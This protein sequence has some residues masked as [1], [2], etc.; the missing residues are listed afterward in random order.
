MHPRKRPLRCVSIGDAIAE[1]VLGLSDIPFGTCLDLQAEE[2]RRQRTAAE[3]N[4]AAAQDQAAQV[5][6][7]MSN[8]AL[9]LVPLP[10]LT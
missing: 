6:Q 9:H 1:R 8:T 3:Q 2:A 7:P 4:T 10:A 5:G